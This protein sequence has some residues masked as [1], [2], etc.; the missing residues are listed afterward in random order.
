MNQDFEE[1]KNGIPVHGFLKFEEAITPKIEDLPAAIEDLKMEKEALVLADD[2]QTDEIKKS[3]DFSG[4]PEDIIRQV[5]ETEKDFIVLCGKKNWAETLKILF[6]EKRILVP[7]LLA[8]SFRLR[9]TTG[10]DIQKMRKESS[11]ICVISDIESDL[12]VKAES[13]IVALGENLLKT[14]R[15]IEK[16]KKVI[17]VSPISL[18]QYLSRKCAREVEGI[19]VNENSTYPSSRNTLEKLYICLNYE[20]P[21]IAIDEKYLADATQSHQ[22]LIHP[23]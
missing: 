4:S 11:N 12:D 21:E 8:G 19:N 3:A 16:S 5:Q 15:K 10:Q 20:L 13:D 17:Y 22:N 6:P 18:A 14:I 23:E 1:A 7:D 9:S 2:D